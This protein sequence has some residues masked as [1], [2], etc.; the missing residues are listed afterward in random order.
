[1]QISNT[2]GLGK[3]IKAIRISKNLTQAD[4]AC[5]TNVGVR[6]IVDS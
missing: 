4:L 1:M 2:A 5:A 6:F 3:V